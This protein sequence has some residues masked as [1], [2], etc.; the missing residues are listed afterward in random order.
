MEILFA[1]SK[2]I[3]EQEDT[4]V[5]IKDARNDYLQFVDGKMPKP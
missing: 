2:E 1:G 4:F 3:F 5:D